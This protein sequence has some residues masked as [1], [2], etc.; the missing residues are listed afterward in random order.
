VKDS[1]DCSILIPVGNHEKTGLSKLLDELKTLYPQAEIICVGTKDSPSSLP[2]GVKWLKTEKGRAR[3]MNEG[4]K[5]ASHSFLWFL[6]ADSQVQI[7]NVQALKQALKANPESLSYFDLSFTD[8]D[9]RLKI[10]AWGAWFRSR[11]FGLPF[12]D[13]GFVLSKKL[14]WDLGG[15]DE[16]APYGEDHLLVW[17]AKKQGVPLNP[18]KVPLGTSARKYLTQGWLKT[19]FHHVFLT[20]LQ[21]FKEFIRPK[22]SSK[23]AIAVFVKTPGLTPLK[24]RLAA[25]LGK[26][27]AEAFYHHSVKAVESVLKNVQ[28]QSNRFQAFWAVAER[29]GLN[30]SLW[31]K[32]SKVYQGEGDLG[33]R[34][35]SVY[36]SLIKKYET[37]LLIGADCPEI[38]ITQLEKAQQSLLEK[39][40]KFVLGPALDGGFYLFGGS[41]PIPRHIWTDTPYSEGAT[42]ERLRKHLLPFG[43]IAFLETARDVDT[44][45]D[46]KALGGKAPSGLTLEQQKLWDWTKRSAI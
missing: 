46:L 28:D 37:V 13:Q 4:A 22:R 32:F 45:E 41:T 25:S 11:I 39:K 33:Q 44:L 5:E 17:A 9:F 34:L 35:D 15:Y 42:L 16:S 2:S 6:H 20:Y 29:E 36:S 27:K 31:K 24:T 1:L 14:F 21:A 12:G 19:T 7:E 10:N 30:H 8:G 38:Q 18:L 43:E 40:S 23:C 3:Q 26:E